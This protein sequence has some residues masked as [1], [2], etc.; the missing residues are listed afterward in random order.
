MGEVAGGQMVGLI[1]EPSG[2]LTLDDLT[3][4]VA[5]A[6]SVRPFVQAEGPAAITRRRRHLGQRRPLD[7]RSRRP[8]L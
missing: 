4:R 1:A 2:A 8:G 3:A 7:R 6:L 5:S